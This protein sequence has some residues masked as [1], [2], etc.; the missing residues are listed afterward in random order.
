VEA[1]NTPPARRSG[2]GIFLTRIFAGVFDFTALSHIE[3]AS[4]F[5]NFYQMKKS[6]PLVFSVLFVFLF[7]S[8]CVR[9]S[10]SRAGRDVS[11]S[12]GGALFS[13]FNYERP[14][15]LTLGSNFVARTRRYE[16]WR[17]A[18]ARAGGVVT[19][20]TT[21]ALDY[22]LPIRAKPSTDA[23]L[24]P[25]VLILP[26][27]AGRYELES[28]LAR[29][30][31]KEFAVVVARRDEI[32]RVLKDNLTGD[33][34]NALLRQSIIDARQII[35]WVETRPELA[36]TKIGVLGVSQGAIRGAVLAAI[37][38]R[39][40]VSV[41]ALGG[42]NVPY[43]IARSKD[44]A[45]KHRGITRRRNEHR[46]SHG[47]SLSEFEGELRR[48]MTSDPL[49]FAPYIDRQR[50][51]LILGLCDSVVP[52]KTGWTLRRAMGKPQ[53]IVLLGG[54]YTV[55]LYLPYII[56]KSVEFFRE[57]FNSP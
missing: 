42:G 3:S 8:G 54:H 31:T 14:A 23:N 15:N 45:L 37:D 29:R 57:G 33:A 47:C 17:V 7:Q 19:T 50:T 30:F 13:Q 53:T 35:D 26:I 40:R 38:R 6:A 25:V 9:F 18:I 20:N 41:L 5:E 48:A 56:Q 39:I 27:S 49:D 52:F 2:A 12:R 28:H 51:L 36:H 43:I 46:A 11:T 16:L 44:G 55:V 32:P 34:V 1:L 24:L 22:Y 4:D 21:L 10:A